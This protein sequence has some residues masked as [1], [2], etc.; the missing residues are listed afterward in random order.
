[1]VMQLDEADVRAV[2]RWDDLII[3]MEKALSPQQQP[4]V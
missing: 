1:M 2:L 4:T 3:A